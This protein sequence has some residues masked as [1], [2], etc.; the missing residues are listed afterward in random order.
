MPDG[1]PP[2]RRLATA[3]FI[4]PA[5]RSTDNKASDLCNVV[6]FLR[7]RSAGGKQGVRALSS[8][9]HPPASKMQT[10][11]AAV[12]PSAPHAYA[13]QSTPPRTWLETARLWCVSLEA[14]TGADTDPRPLAC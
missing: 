11:G 2:P 3:I 13:R 6:E 14:R 4:F 7:R 5:K 10:Q 8:A 9:A 12:A 1:S